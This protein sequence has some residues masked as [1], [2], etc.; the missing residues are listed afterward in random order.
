M[1][2]KGDQIMELKEFEIKHLLKEFK[3]YGVKEVTQDIISGRVFISFDQTPVELVFQIDGKTNIAISI[4]E[5]FNSIE[6][7]GEVYKKA[8]KLK[9]GLN[10]LMDAMDEEE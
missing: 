3:E 6:R 9:Q 4:Q 1:N 8:I 5:F 2:L 10:W 7:N